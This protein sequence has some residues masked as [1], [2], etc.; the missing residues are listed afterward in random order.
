[1]RLQRLRFPEDPR[2]VRLARMKETLCQRQKERNGTRN[3]WD[4]MVL[5]EGG[6][7]VLKAIVRNGAIVPLEPLPAE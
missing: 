7:V 3:Y 6:G 5:M 4:K 2:E 1:V